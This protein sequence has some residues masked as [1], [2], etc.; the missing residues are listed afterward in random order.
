M[1]PFG[2]KAAF[3]SPEFRPSGRERRRR[4][5]MKVHTP[6]YA[7]MNEGPGG[8]LP[9]LSEILDISEDGMCLQTASPLQS[10]C[11]LNLSLDLSESNQH[12]HITGRVIWADQLGRAGIS[13][14]QM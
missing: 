8:T 11:D 14:P 12:I 7:S 9:D 5:R 13:F 3:D 2:T 10:G 6:A 4:V 1:E